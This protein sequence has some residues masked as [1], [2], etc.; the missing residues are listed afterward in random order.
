MDCVVAIVTCCGLDGPGIESRWGRGFPHP[1]K[2]A[3]EPTRPPAQLVPGVKQPGR[4]VKHPPPCRTE[5]KERVE[6]CM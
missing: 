3:L 1:L 5:V 6:V 4:G 2:P